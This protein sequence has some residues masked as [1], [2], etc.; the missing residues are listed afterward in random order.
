MRKQFLI[1]GLCVFLAAGSVI[2][3]C[4]KHEGLY[5]GNEIGFKYED[6]NRK[7]IDDAVKIKDEYTDQIIQ[8]LEKIE[9]GCRIVSA[10]ETGEID[11]GYLIEIKTESGNEYTVNTA[12]DG[13]IG[14]ITDKKTGK[15]LYPS[16]SLPEKKDDADFVNSMDIN[17]AFLMAK[18][19]S[20]EN[21]QKI[22]EVIDHGAPNEVINRI[23]G[24]DP[25]TKDIRIII[26]METGKKFYVTVKEEDEWN[27]TISDKDF[28]DVL[29]EAY[30]DTSEK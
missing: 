23:E 12:T 8:L 28:C 20:K 24:Y 9:P 16:D 17:T 2:S 15:M 22:A 4:G 25:D 7:K 27:A 18:G 30:G 29:E 13:M 11:G 1:T 19:I 6:E 3:G 21:A 26:Y 14:N 10:E 5:A